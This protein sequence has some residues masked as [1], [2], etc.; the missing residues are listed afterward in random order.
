[1]GP[2]YVQILPKPWDPQS[3]VWETLFQMG[4]LAL[5]LPIPDRVN[6]CRNLLVPVHSGW[7]V[8]T[9]GQPCVRLLPST[10]FSGPLHP[11]VAQKTRQIPFRPSCAWP[12]LEGSSGG[13][14]E[15]FQKPRWPSEGSFFFIWR[16]LQDGMRME[17]LDSPGWTWL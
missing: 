13:I 5:G 7:G 10:C 8:D 9:L 17:S 15:C 16:G 4:W 2:C 11:P 6:R 3:T 1:M 14:R 12:K